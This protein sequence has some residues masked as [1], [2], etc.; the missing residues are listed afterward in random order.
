MTNTISTTRASLVTLH[1]PSLLQRETRVVGRLPIHIAVVKDAFPEVIHCQYLCRA[2]PQSLQCKDEE[3]NLPLHYAAMHG[4]P[5]VLGSLLE[6]YP[7]ASAVPNTRDRYPL[8]LVCARCYDTEP[9][10]TQLLESLIQAHPSALQ[11]LDRFGRT[12]MHLAANIH[13]RNGKS[14]KY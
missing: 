13:V 8:H 1:P 2:R 11:N 6:T 5:Q 7:H 12:P 9:I 4:S 14:S 3:G 10:P